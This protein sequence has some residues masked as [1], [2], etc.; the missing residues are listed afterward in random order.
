M[1]KSKLDE[2]VCITSEE[3]GSSH[4]TGCIVRV[5]VPLCTKVYSQLGDEVFQFGSFPIKV[6]R[7]FYWVWLI[8]S[9]LDWHYQLLLQELKLGMQIL[10]HLALLLQLFSEGTDNS[11]VRLVVDFAHPW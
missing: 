3:L 2:L 4:A 7:L 9:Y 11:S 1:I 6:C 5:L 10:P 8:I